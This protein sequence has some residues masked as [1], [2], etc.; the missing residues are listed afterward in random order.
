MKYTTLLF[1]LDDTLFDFRRAEAEALRRTL[2]SLNQP[3]APEYEALYAACNQQV[4]KEFERGQIESA[5]LRVKRFRLFFERLH[6]PASSDPQ[7][8]S[9]VYLH[10]LAQGAFLL[11]GAEELI[12]ALRPRCRLAL[13]TNGLSDVQRPRL[14][15]SPLAESFDGLFIS[16]EIG[17]AKPSPAYFDAVFQALGNPSR[18]STLL[19]GDSLTSDMQG[20]L[21]YGLD[22]CWY[23]PRGAT[24][25]LPVTVQI[26]RLADLLP[27]LQTA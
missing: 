12:R 23:N 14:A 13:V 24:P 21:N 15:A 11:P 18:S 6:L 7:A 9:P 5:E 20:G 27:W 17:A 19:I 8:V 10:F 3:F 26:Q 22:T 2:E 16:E 25:S 1:D 4:W